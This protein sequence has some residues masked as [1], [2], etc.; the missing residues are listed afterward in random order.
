MPPAFA[1]SQVARPDAPAAAASADR[2][3]LGGSGGSVA[4]TNAAF[5]VH[6]VNLRGSTRAVAA[7][8]LLADTT[9]LAN[10]VSLRG[11]VVLVQRGVCSMVSKARAAQLA[12]MVLIAEVS[13]V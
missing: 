13:A 5:G 9:P 11:S 3:V 6:V 4:C 1:S 12:A 7:Q 10:A 2:I 8:P